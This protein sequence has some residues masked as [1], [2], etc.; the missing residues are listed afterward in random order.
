MES[1]P[2]V[3]NPTPDDNT[4]DVTTN[5]PLN[6]SIVF[7]SQGTTI[8]SDFGIVAYVDDQDGVEGCVAVLTDSNNNE[9][10]IPMTFRGFSRYRCASEPVKLE[11]LANGLVSLKIKVNDKKGNAEVSIPI[12]SESYDNTFQI[13]ENNEQK[14]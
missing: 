14:I 11:S 9:V 7:P 5:E 8:E 1:L 2:P 3:A 10:E 13:G 4:P 12:F 6:V